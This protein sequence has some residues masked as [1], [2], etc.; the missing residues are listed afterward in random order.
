[1]ADYFIEL[2][3]N[4]GEGFAP[5]HRERRGYYGPKYNKPVE[6]RY[7]FSREVVWL[8]RDDKSFILRNKN[9]TN[10]NC[11]QPEQPTAEGFDDVVQPDD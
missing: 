10:H 7:C 9:G 6:C 11:R 2:G 5:R 4:S 3:L 8:Q 1:M